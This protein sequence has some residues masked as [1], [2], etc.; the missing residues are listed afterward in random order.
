M[1]AFP[2]NFGCIPLSVVIMTTANRMQPTFSG[3]YTQHFII[4]EL[5]WSFLTFHGKCWSALDPCYA[6]GKHWSYKTLQIISWRFR[7]LW[8]FKTLMFFCQFTKLLIVDDSGALCSCTVQGVL[9]KLQHLTKLYLSLDM[10]NI[11]ITV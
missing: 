9:K 11:S 4:S 6:K 1:Y 8:H 5:Y 3:R 2:K 7:I 10:Y